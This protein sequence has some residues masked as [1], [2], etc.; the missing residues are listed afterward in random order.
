MVEKK[1]AK[2]PARTKVFLKKSPLATEDCNE[3]LLEEAKTEEIAE[4]IKR[5]KI[6]MREGRISSQ[7]DANWSCPPGR[8]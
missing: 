5:I 6:E 7:L 1:V 8:P 4:L 2:M 3:A